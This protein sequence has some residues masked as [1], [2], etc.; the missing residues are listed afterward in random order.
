MN[1]GLHRNFDHHTSVDA[2]AVIEPVRQTIRQ[3]VYQALKERGPMTDGELE[4]LEQF[5]HCGASTVR[6]R[7]S[8]LYQKGLVEKD[9]DNRRGG[10]TVWRIR[11]RQRKLF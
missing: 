6:K 10:M 3:K 5:K 9:G 8:E 4:R 7:R 2:A 11:Q 1:E